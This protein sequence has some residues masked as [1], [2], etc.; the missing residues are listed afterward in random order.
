MVRLHLHLDFFLLLLLPT[1]V[2]PHD[3]TPPTLLKLTLAE[4][5]TDPSV[6]LLNNFLPPE[7]ERNHSD[8]FHPQYLQVMDD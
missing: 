7:E 4:G 6:I 1:N 8:S 5:L 2:T 3:S